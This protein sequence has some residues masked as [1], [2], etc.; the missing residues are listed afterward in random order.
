MTEPEPTPVGATDTPEDQD[1]S[2][3]R[4]APTVGTSANGPSITLN[5]EAANHDTL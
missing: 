1:A 2:T 5:I 3:A 4:V